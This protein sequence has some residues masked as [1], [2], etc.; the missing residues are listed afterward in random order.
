M[1]VLSTSQPQKRLRFVRAS[2]LMLFSLNIWSN[3]CMNLAAV[4]DRR[5]GPPC[6]WRKSE[7]RGGR[8]A[9]GRKNRGGLEHADQESR[10]RGMKSMKLEISLALVCLERLDLTWLASPSSVLPT[11]L[12]TT[13]TFSFPTF[14]TCHGSGVYSLQPITHQSKHKNVPSDPGMLV[15]NW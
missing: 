6:C 5:Y 11:R 14:F 1:A 15:A 8:R 10:G 3:K 9:P 4:R 7:C 2:T 12:P 13:A